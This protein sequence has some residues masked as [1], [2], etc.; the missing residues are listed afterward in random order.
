MLKSM[1]KSN[2]GGEWGLCIT[3][4]QLDEDE[5]FMGSGFFRPCSLEF[6]VQACGV[7]RSRRDP[8][9]AGSLQKA[10]VFCACS[11]SSKTSSIL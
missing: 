9:E 5:E 6:C 2:L 10:C 1:E 4:C 7:D 11:S 3:K 8:Q